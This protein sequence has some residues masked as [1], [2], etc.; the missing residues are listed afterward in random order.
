MAKS[1]VGYMRSIYWYLVIFGVC[2][3][4]TIG[5]V[6]RMAHATGMAKSDIDGVPDTNKSPTPGEDKDKYGLNTSCWRA[7]LSFATY[8]R[9]TILM[10]SLIIY[11]W[12]SSIVNIL[13]SLHISILLSFHYLCQTTLTYTYYLYP[14]F[15]Y[16]WSLLLSSGTCLLQFSSFHPRANHNIL[17][18]S[19]LDINTDIKTAADLA[20]AD[21]AKL[22]SEGQVL[23]LQEL[24]ELNNRVKAL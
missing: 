4:H 11:L 2:D 7:S 12:Y 9:D 20:V 8:S 16:L 18:Q 15:W 3:R 21:L 24:K 1:G 19:T 13:L 23:S 14:W 10:Y 5:E 6:W 22:R 17:D